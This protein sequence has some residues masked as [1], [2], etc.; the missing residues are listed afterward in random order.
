MNY[1]EKSKAFLFHEKRLRVSLTAPVQ[2]LRKAIVAQSEIILLET[3]LIYF[4]R[5]SVFF[6]FP[7][8]TKVAKII[9]K[10]R[11]KL[12]LAAS[13]SPLPNT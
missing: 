9:K 4:V 3:A 10:K 8:L 7:K 2:M 11:H 12:I 6:S 1:I 13:R 5:S